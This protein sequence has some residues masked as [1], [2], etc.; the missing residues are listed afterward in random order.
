MYNARLENAE[1]LSADLTHANFGNAD[2]TGANLSEAILWRTK[3]EDANLTNVI[4]DNAIV[5][6]QDWIDYIDSTWNVKGARD[7]ANRY[8]TKKQGKQQFILIPKK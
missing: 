4:L 7:I 3:L 6:R 8:T 5:D 1:L 2:L